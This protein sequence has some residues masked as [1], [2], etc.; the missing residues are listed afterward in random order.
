MKRAAALLLVAGL[1]MGASQGGAKAETLRVA[2]GRVS[3]ET[4]RAHVEFLADD[5]LEGREAGTRGYDVAARYVASELAQAGVAPAGDGGTFFQEVPLLESRLVSGSVSWKDAAGA[6]TT[7]AAGED[8]VMA[9]D[10]QRA[11][12]RVEAAVVFAGHGVTAPRQ[13]HDDYAGLE[14]KGRIVALLPNAP[15]GFP[16]EERAYHASSSRKAENAAAHGAVGILFLRTPEDDAR[17]PW[18]RVRSYAEGPAM[19]WTHPDGRPEGVWPTLRGGA[20]LS[21]QA[22]RRLL[23]GAPVPADDVFARAAKE[24][25]A[26]FALGVTATL[27]SRTEHTRTRSR[28]VVGRLEGSDPALRRSHLVYSA[29]LDHVGVAKAPDASG[30]PEPAAPG[31]ADRIHNGAFDNALG[32]AVVLEIA[33]VL[34]GLE[35]RPRRSVLFLFVTAE[36]KGLLG[37]DYFASRPTVEA[38]SLAANVNIDMPLLLFPI[39]DVVAFGSENSTLDAAIEAGASAVDLPLSPDPM[40]QE[41]IFV[42]SDQYSFVRK[43]V[44]AVMFMPGFRSSDASID[45]SKRVGEFLARHYHR[46]SDDLSLPMDL[47]S[48]RRFTQANVAVGLAITESGE[49]PRYK[50]GNF[51]GETFPRAAQPADR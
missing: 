15:A 34:A 47:A 29:H 4:V 18:A 23:A 39:G 24:R 30:A 28:N 42:R 6:A 9:G 8:F 33:R 41:T 20:L 46:P 50:P 1:G 31:E 44:P 2:L 17:T 38:A 12:S 37:S 27:A 49:S 22:T 19:R 45:G 36:E 7:L 43:G 14:V 16:S 25:V 26:G 10:S 13:G 40:P 48:I 11:A 51:F 32:S 21:L 5:L 3:A 35:P